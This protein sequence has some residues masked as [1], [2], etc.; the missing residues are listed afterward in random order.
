MYDDILGKKAKKTL[1]P[2]SVICKKCNKPFIR[3]EGLGTKLEDQPCPHCMGDEIIKEFK[4]LAEVQPM[5]DNIFKI[6]NKCPKCGSTN[7]EGVEPFDF[8]KQCKDCNNQFVTG[9]HN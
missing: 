9:E 5:P 8:V 4:E 1:K 2:T 6:E 7:I 3:F